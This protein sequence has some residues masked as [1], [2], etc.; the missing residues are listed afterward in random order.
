MERVKI[1]DEG[2]DECHRQIATV[3][4]CGTVVSLKLNGRT[5]SGPHNNAFTAWEPADARKI[6]A[7]LNA[8]PMPWSSR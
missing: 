1:V 4:Q 8:A 2:K 6:A 3:S 5:S 7:A